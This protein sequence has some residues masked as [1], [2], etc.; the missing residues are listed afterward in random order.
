[1]RK[2]DPDHIG[3][4]IGLIALFGALSGLVIALQWSETVGVPMI[5]F[6][7]LL[8]IAGVLVNYWI[9]YKRSKRGRSK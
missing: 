5:Q 6:S 4:L 7:V 2:P 1:M 3:I 8:G 9:M